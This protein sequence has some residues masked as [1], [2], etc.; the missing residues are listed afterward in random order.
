M[1]RERGDLYTPSIT[2]SKTYGD[3]ERNLSGQNIWIRPHMVN[4]KIN[5][6]IRLPIIL[7]MLT[8]KKGALLKDVIELEHNY[9]L[10]SDS[11]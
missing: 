5:G 2:L 8:S 6:F 3:Q 10:T 1:R 4:T 11:E 9:T 7:R